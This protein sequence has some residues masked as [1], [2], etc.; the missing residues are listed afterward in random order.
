MSEER[1]YI[2]I[3]LKSFFASVECVERGLDPMKTNLVVA[4]PSRTEKTICLAVTPAMKELGVKNRCRVFEI[5]KGIDYIMAPP[6][7]QLYIDYSAEIYKIYL[8]YFSEEDIHPYSIDE[9]FIDVT[10]YKKLY[11]LDSEEALT[12]NPDEVTLRKYEGDG[13]DIEEQ[14]IAGNLLGAKKIGMMLM[15]EILAKLGIMAT[16]GVGTNLYLTKIALDIMAKRSPDRVGVLDQ[17]MYKK[18]LWDYRPLT[19]FWRIGKGTANRLL[20][21]GITTMRD[22]AEADEDLMYDIFGIDAELLVDHAWGIEPVTISDIKKYKPKSSG[23]SHG[24][25]LSKDYNK[26]DA[27]IVTKE[28]ADVLCLDLVDKG[29]A[30]TSVT[31]LVGYS[32]VYDEKPARGSFTLAQPSSS[33]KTISTELERVF[34]EVVNE[35]IPIRRI[36]LSFNKVVPEVFRQYDLFTDPEEADRERSIQ[37][38][39]LKIKKK[40]GKNALLRATDLQENATMKERNEQIGGHK[41]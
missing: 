21:Y 6:R 15:D 32:N 35:N 13:I 11:H 19:D 12:K 3:D 40:Y 29:L 2:C 9:V 22:I 4:D 1:S 14:E 28:M 36:N 27:L 30:A 20:K 33:Y 25:V 17:D 37:E 24:Q 8:K 5:P 38:A 31:V 10:N 7:M 41:K 34:N 23:L 39:A 16:C 26:K 18:N